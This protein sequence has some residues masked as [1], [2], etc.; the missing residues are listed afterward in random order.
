[1]L[2]RGCNRR[3]VSIQLD[4]TSSRKAA[5]R[6]PQSW[7]RQYHTGGC[8]QCLKWPQPADEGLRPIIGGLCSMATGSRLTRG[9]G[10]A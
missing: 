2:G 4:V 10:P 1:M 5:M 3:S 7:P 9:Y 6:L 8:G